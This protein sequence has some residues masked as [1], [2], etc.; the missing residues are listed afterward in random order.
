[1]ADALNIADP[2][3]ARLAAWWEHLTPASLATLTSVY[4]EHLHFVDPFNDVRGA[5][6]LLA[7]LMRMFERLDEPRFV[8][9]DVASQA[10]G[11][12]LIWDFHYRLRD[13]Q[14]TRQRLIHGASH[15]RFG[16]DG[17]VIEHRDYWDAAAQVYAQ[18]PLLGG[19]LRWL[20][21]RIG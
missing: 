14:P 7:L 9:L 21:H 10:H 20:R 11:A 3:V 18:L 19:V 6:A 15:V 12:V 4:D 16:A 1:M 2:R 17:R 8:M 13:W 5:A